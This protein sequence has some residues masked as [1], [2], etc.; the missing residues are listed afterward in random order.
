MEKFS[1]YPFIYRQKHEQPDFIVYL[2]L[3]HE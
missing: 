2:E 1:N 3:C